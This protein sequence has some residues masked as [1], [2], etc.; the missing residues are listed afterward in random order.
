MNFR[1]QTLLGSSLSPCLLYTILIYGDSSLPGTGPLSTFSFF[2][3]NIYNFIC[4]L[5][6]VKTGKIYEAKTG[7]IKKRNTTLQ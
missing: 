3:L 4:Q 6:A 7:N 2:F 1:K 5:Y